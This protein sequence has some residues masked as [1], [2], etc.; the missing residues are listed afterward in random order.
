[1]V[2]L[3]RYVEA[4]RILGEIAQSGSSGADKRVA[5]GAKV[6]LTKLEQRL[7]K[8]TIRVV[9]PPQER[10]HVSVDE[11]DVDASQE[12]PLDPGEHV[13]MAEAPGFYR[14]VR[15][16]RAA[17]GERLSEELK[18]LPEPA[19]PAPAPAIVSHPVEPKEREEA[20]GSVVP[21]ALAFGLGAAGIGVGIA[22][23]LMASSEADEVKAGC[24]GNQCGKEVEDGLASA[25]TKGT[26]ST[27]GFVAGGVGLV[28]GIVLLIV[29]PGKPASS[30]EG[31]D[32]FV[33][34]WIGPAAV[35][36]RGAF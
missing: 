7:P 22:F 33:T 24:N 29:K 4:H 31:R 13:L 3:K 18:L 34:P 1:L 14:L 6:Q 11:Q 35:G 9:G 19:K 17:D 8:L 2:G 21:A 30:S 27:I 16:V 23:G 12:I 10:T 26:V 15:R 20:G 5:A 32:A 36:A 25:K 28:G